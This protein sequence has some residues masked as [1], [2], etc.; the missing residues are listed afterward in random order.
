[1]GIEQGEPMTFEEADERRGNPH[2]VAGSCS[3]YTINCASSV[4]AN[5]L[6]RRGFD[7]EAMMNTR[8]NSNIPYQLSRQ[9]EMVWIDPLTGKPPVSTKVGVTHWT[10]KEGD[11]PV[12]QSIERSYRDSMAAQGV[13]MENFVPVNTPEEAVFLP[14][15]RYHLRMKWEGDFGLDGGHIVAFEKT[16]PGKYRFIDPQTGK[17]DGLVR[18][19]S[20]GAYRKKAIAEL[21][22]VDT[23]MPNPDYLGAVSKAGTTKA[24]KVKYAKKSGGWSGVMGS[25]P[26][27]ERLR[28]R[29]KE[30][31]EE[32]KILTEQTFQHPQIKEPIKIYGS[33]IK[34]WLNQPHKHIVE[35]NEMLLNIGEVLKNA[36]Y[37]GCNTYKG[38]VSHI[39]ET[40][41][42]GKKT[43]IVVTE[44]QGRGLVIH[45]ISDNADVLIG[46]KKP[47]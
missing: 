29:R 43:W 47:S 6:R 10:M 33:G 40:T 5:E 23:L 15:G 3:G 37:K 24:S 8:Q 22:R 41:L 38:H 27:T 26:L 25:S 36:E 35:K 14:N 42:M 4:F 28:Q 7:V 18:L 19:A 34:E 12:F 17:T 30:I 45:S 20:G 21:Y 44:H 46:L 16:E 32:A 13:K 9:T 2:Y 31:R 39:F 1:M 11:W